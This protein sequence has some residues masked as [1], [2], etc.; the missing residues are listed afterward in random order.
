MPSYH[1]KWYTRIFSDPKIVEDLLRSFVTEDFVKDLDFTSLKKLNGKFVPVSGNSRHADIVYEIK[2]HGISTFI[3]IF[4]EFQS[5][6]DYN[7]AMRMARYMLEFYQENEVKCDSLYCP[8]FA[9][10]IYSGNAKWT[11]SDSLRDLFIKSVVPNKYIPD[12]HYFKIAINE[13][14]KRDLVRIRSAVSTIFYVE[15]STPEEIACNYSELF[16][17]FRSII[18]KDPDAVRVVDAIVERIY[19]TQKIEDKAPVIKSIDDLVEAESMWEMAVKEYQ[20]KIK[21]Q[22]KLEG[23]EQG[24]IEDAQKMLKMG[25]PIEQ[26]AQITGFDKEKIERLKLD[27]FLW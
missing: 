24:K 7:M 1:D 3:Y 13:I 19:K 10:L 18:E 9:I 17:L 25:L 6:V 16:S 11:A 20:Q 26:I 12:F 23:I 8:P 2:S 27:N 15:N 4:L 22:G 5:T 21:A 14:P